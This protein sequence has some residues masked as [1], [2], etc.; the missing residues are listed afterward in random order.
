[1]LADW[2]L[3]GCLEKSLIAS[4]IGWGRPIIV[5]L[6]GPFRSW[7]YPKIFRSRRVKNAIAASAS[8][9]VVKMEEKNVIIIAVLEGLIFMWVV[10]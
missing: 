10:N 2:G 9:Y 4:A 1:M 8:K 5:T 3:D 7:L 6:L